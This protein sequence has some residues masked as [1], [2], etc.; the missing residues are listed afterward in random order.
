MS[1]RSPKQSSQVQGIIVVFPGLLDIS[2]ILYVDKAH[3][4][5][6]F[7]RRS[8]DRE[9]EIY[10]ISPI[11]PS[12][13]GEDDDA[14]GKRASR[15]RVRAIQLLALSASSYCS[16]VSSKPVRHTHT[17]R[18]V[19]IGDRMGHVG[20]CTILYINYRCLRRSCFDQ[21]KKRQSGLGGS[22]SHTKRRYVG[23]CV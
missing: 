1:L 10:N 17:Y 16:H 14:C 4:F 3:N 6:L 21:A 19:P 8:Y 18:L 15:T 22:F 9:L 5:T 23:L 13:G 7:F 2:G 11:N 12:A 20:I